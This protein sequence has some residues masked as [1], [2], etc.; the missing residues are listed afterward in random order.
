MGE[1]VDAR[2]WGEAYICWVGVPNQRVGREGQGEAHG[3]Y[4]GALCEGSSGLAGLIN[5]VA[6][7]DDKT[8]APD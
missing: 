8:S 4:S 2:G 5:E 3:D 1:R 7:G 6:W